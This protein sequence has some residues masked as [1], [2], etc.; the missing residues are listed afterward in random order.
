TD[1]VDFNLPCPLNNEN[2]Q[3]YTS[4]YWGLVGDY[5]GSIIIIPRF[6][7]LVL[8]YPVCFLVSILLLR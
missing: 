2:R 3:I 5:Y 1:C 7:L 6:L 4:P 8:L